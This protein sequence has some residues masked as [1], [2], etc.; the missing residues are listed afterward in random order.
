MNSESQ[1]RLIAD[2]LIS[3]IHSA[4]PEIAT[5]LG[6][7]TAETREQI[8]SVLRE[9]D[10]QLDDVFVNRVVKQF[11]KNYPRRVRRQYS[12]SAV[13]ERH[14]LEIL[15]TI[16]RS[17]FCSYALNMKSESFIGWLIQQP[18]TTNGLAN[19]SIAYLRSMMALSYDITTRFFH[20][21]ISLLDKEQHLLQGVAVQNTPLPQNRRAHVVLV[22]VGS[23]ACFLFLLFWPFL[24]DPN[25]PVSLWSRIAKS[26]FGTNVINGSGNIVAALIA[27][28]VATVG[29]VANSRSVVRRSELSKQSERLLAKVQLARKFSEQMIEARISVVDSLRN[30]QI[31]SQTTNLSTIDNFHDRIEL[32]ATQYGNALDALSKAV[33]LLKALDDNYEKQM[34]PSINALI[35]FNSVFQSFAE[36]P[37]LGDSSDIDTQA[38]IL[39]ETLE[40]DSNELLRSIFS[41][42]STSSSMH[43]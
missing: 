15:S 36:L 3:I 26:Q 29:Y 18:E 43:S 19:D 14:F 41:T 4:Q 7:L 27:A 5:Q 21:L 42:R 34:R 35:T 32:I 6:L 9:V 8:N 13:T 39:A 25:G 10:I 22:V 37:T 16:D 40:K 38:E 20:D 12:E 2:G 24:S 17:S 31:L 30:I 11:K 28:T 23:V 1:Y 33:N